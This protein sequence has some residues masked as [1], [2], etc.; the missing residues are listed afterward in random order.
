MKITSSALSW[1]SRSLWF[2][3][4]L[5]CSVVYE[6]AFLTVSFR[7]YDRWTFTRVLLDAADRISE[8]LIKLTVYDL[9]KTNWKYFPS[10]YF[11]IFQRSYV[12]DCF[13]STKLR[14][15]QLYVVLRT[16][17]LGNETMFLCFIASRTSRVVRILLVALRSHCNYRSHFVSAIVYRVT[18]NERKKQNRR[19]ERTQSVRNTRKK[20]QRETRET[21]HSFAIFRERGKSSLSEAFRPARWRNCEIARM[22]IAVSCKLF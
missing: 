12:Y 15:S 19:R 8:Y 16:L 14:N 6:R 20:K 22:S 17:R 21:E 7:L 1:R 13:P 18:Y 5:M 3:S 11:L 10:S 4:L 9:T 2:S